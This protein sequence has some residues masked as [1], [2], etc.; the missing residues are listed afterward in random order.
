[1]TAIAR[2]FA[3][4]W[5]AVSPVGATAKESALAFRAS[6]NA[7]RESAIPDSAGAAITMGLLPTL[8]PTLEGVPRLVALADLALLDLLHTAHSLL[9]GRDVRLALVLDPAP[10]PDW[11]AA[12]PIADALGARLMAL[13][14][15]TRAP[16]VYAS[17]SIGLVEALR[18]AAGSG[19]DALTIVVAVH[20]DHC[21]KTTSLLASA[22]RIWGEDSLDAILLGE[23]AGALLVSAREPRHLGVPIGVRVDLSELTREPAT[24]DNDE[25]AFVAAGLTVA[26][27]AITEA[28]RARGER[29]G[30]I[31]SDVS[32]EAF[33]VHELTTILTRLQDRLGP[34]Q[35]LETPNQRLGHLG[36]AVG[37]F[38][39]AAAG[40]AF[41]REFAPAAECLCLLGTDA[42]VRAALLLGAERAS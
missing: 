41:A 32:F 7:L 15:F 27:R 17:G 25:S 40:E 37:A 16:S 12:R 21:L 29:V 13:G 18:S 9:A 1:M 42:G 20:S 6:V 34:P 2:V 26:T 3:L 8:A 30:W 24:P 14:I 36:A 23:G 4:A 39:I 28:P 22:G 38:Q 10:A 5:G 31:S 11:D 35:V 19:P 33:R